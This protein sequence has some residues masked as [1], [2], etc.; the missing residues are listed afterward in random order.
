MLSQVSLQLCIDVWILNY[1]TPS[2]RRDGHQCSP[3]PCGLHIHRPMSR[4][5]T[6]K[7]KDNR[8]NLEPEIQRQSFQTFVG[9]IR[10][11]RKVTCSHCGRL[12]GGS[13]P[14][15]LCRNRKSIQSRFVETRCTHNAIGSG[16]NEIDIIPVISQ[17]CAILMKGWSSHCNEI[18]PE[19]KSLRI[20]I[21]ALKHQLIDKCHNAEYV[22]FGG[23]L[24][25]SCTHHSL[26]HGS[27]RHVL[28]P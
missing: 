18:L 21:G 6:C 9:V 16:T 4:E 2:K 26:L 19:R 24:C 14:P 13:W 10:V 20:H 11:L 12:I 17:S 25:Q 27:A 23:R 7:L 1:G 8:I 15:N 3:F 28:K 5:K 22:Q